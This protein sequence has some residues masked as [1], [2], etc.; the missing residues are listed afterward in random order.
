H[1]FAWDPSIASLVKKEWPGIVSKVCTDPAY[2]S[3]WCAPAL[4]AY[5]K[6]IREED[7]DFRMRSNRCSKNNL[8]NGSKKVHH[9]QGSISAEEVKI[10]LKKKAANF[11]CESETQKKREEELFLRPTYW[12]EKVK[13]SR[14]DCIKSLKTQVVELAAKNDNQKTREVFIET[15]RTLIETTKSFM[16]FKQQ[17]ETFMQANP[18]RSSHHGL[19]MIF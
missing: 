15:R 12:N 5:M 18:R 10:N 7:E 16:T 17:V 9:H 14:R 1:D 4:R 13:K 8:C 3:T 6:H 11:K 2:T 19:H